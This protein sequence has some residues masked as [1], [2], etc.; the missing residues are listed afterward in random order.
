MQ[1]LKLEIRVYSLATKLKA[2]TQKGQKIKQ[3]LSNIPAPIF[4][5]YGELRLVSI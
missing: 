4:E 3:L 5:S 2:H 1:L